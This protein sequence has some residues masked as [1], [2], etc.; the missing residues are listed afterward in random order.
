MKN[1]NFTETD[2]E[3]IKK[4]D[5]AYINNKGVEAYLAGKYEIASEYYQVAA[6]M[7]C[8]NSM[9]NLGYYY[10]YHSNPTNPN[11]ALAYFS[12]AANFENVEA[13]YKLGD[14]YR[15]GIGVEKD[16]ELGLY[17]FNK[18]LELIENDEDKDYRDYP[19]LYFAL[20]K[21]F[22]EDGA[23]D[24][25]LRKAYFYLYNSAVGYD[26]QLSEGMSYYE[27]SFNAVD[28]LLRSKLF[29]GIREE[30][31]KLMNDD[32]EEHHCCGHCNHE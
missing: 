27:S 32:Q 12:V 21:E 13:I 2:I 5:Y 23:Y 31:D 29:D 14:M 17:Y 16:I 18:A 6:T 4:D 15:N 19:S 1:F 25:N 7:G 3:A 28:K 20:G 30:F 10:L 11:K 22:L 8:D 9:S 26:L 24:T